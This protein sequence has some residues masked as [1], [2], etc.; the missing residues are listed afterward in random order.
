MCEIFWNNFQEKFRDVKESLDKASIVSLDCELTGL[1]SIEGFQPSLFD[2]GAERYEKL[3]TGVDQLLVIQLGLTA[4]ILNKEEDEY[5]ARTFTFYLLPTSFLS[6][7]TR[8][9][10]QASSLCFLSYAGFDFNKL[11]SEGIPYLSPEQES[12]LRLDLK[13]DRPALACHISS[14]LRSVLERACWQ[15]SQ[16]TP[17][18]LPGQSFKIFPHPAQKLEE[19]DDDNIVSDASMPPSLTFQLRENLIHRELRLTF[20][21]IWTYPEDGSVIRIE[22]IKEDERQRLE[23]EEERKI[24]E[25]Y[26]EKVFQNMEVDCLA[27]RIIQLLLGATKIFRLLI[28][29]KKPIIGYKSSWFFHNKQKKSDKGEKGLEMTKNAIKI[30]QGDNLDQL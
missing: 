28:E 26:G 13:R 14:D 27:E 11:F 17:S 23:R 9:V 2:S 10:C 20:P 5:L 12:R 21:D 7:D 16:W 19:M 4:F 24:K 3:R 1:H 22:K 8:F 15:V 6:V 29:A 25:E 18:A 30:I